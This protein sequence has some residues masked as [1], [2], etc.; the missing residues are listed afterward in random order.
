M[1][2]TMGTVIVV[3]ALVL[4]SPMWALAGNGKGVMDGTGPAPKSDILQGTAFN[5]TGIVVD[6]NYGQGLVIAV[7]EDGETVNMTILGIGPERYWD[8][9]EMERPCVGDEITVVGYTIT[10]GELDLNIAFTITF[11]G[12]SSIELRDPD[13]G[14]PL[15]RKA[16]L[17]MN[18][19]GIEE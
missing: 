18:K 13:T 10:A 4:L 8:L 9:M 7:D 12:E 3:L 6:C 14:L 16:K 19:K 1:K 17:K 15:W 2:R 5:V 11:A